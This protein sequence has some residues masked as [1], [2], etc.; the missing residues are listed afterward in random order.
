[1]SSRIAAA[2]AETCAALA[3]ARGQKLGNPNGA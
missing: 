3:A 2:T 1:M